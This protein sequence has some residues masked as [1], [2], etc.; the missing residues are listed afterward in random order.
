MNQ[1]VFFYFTNH[2]HRSVIYIYII[3]KNEI[4]NLILMFETDTAIRKKKSKT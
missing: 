3:C 1:L 2:K 4:Q